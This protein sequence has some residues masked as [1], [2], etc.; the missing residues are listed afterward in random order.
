MIE[1]QLNEYL[2]SA[3]SLA[4][5]YRVHDCCTMPADW[6]IERGYDDPMRLWRGRYA[7]ESAANALIAEYGLLDM[8]TLGMIDAGIPECD[9][10]RI[11]DIG[12]VECV[13]H[14]GAGVVG[15]IYGGRRWHALS[16]RGLFQASMTPLR[17]WRVG[18]PLKD[19][20]G[21]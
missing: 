9:E 5:E 13:S 19:A 14:D 7:N 16:E 21:G 4:F 1:V 18:N 12:V 3:A 15:A 20:V 17:I 2:K 6:A 8:W 11:G 10:P